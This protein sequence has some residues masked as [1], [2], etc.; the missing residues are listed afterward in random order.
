MKHKSNGR[1]RYLALLICGIIIFCSE[2]SSTH[3]AKGQSIDGQP[4]SASTYR[5]FQVIGTE[6]QVERMI[7]IVSSN[8]PQWA[9]DVNQ[10]KKR[11]TSAGERPFFLTPIPFVVPP[12]NSQEPFYNHNHQPAITWLPNGDLLAIWYTTQAEHGT[13]L[14]VLASRLRANATQWDPSSEFFKAENH[15]MHGSSL[16]HDG[17]GTIYHF[18]GK[19]PDGETSWAKLALLMRTSN[20]NGVTWTAPLAIA[21]EYRQRNQVISD[22]LLTRNGTLIVACDASPESNGGTALHISRNHGRTWFD[23]GLDKMHPT[24]AADKTGEG[25]IAGIHAKVVELDDGR[26]LAFG[27]GDTINGNMP[28]SISSD[29]GQHWNYT[30]SEFPPIG[31]G[32]R[33]VLRRLN[34]GPILFVSFTRLNQVKEQTPGLV[35]MDQQGKQIRGHGLFAAVSFDDGK[36]W[37]V[38]KLLTPGNGIWDGGAWTKQFQAS[39]NRAEPAGYLAVTQTP[40][41]TIHLI[42]SRLHYRFNLAWLLQGT[43]HAKRAPE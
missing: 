5:R 12:T 36:T 34:E 23:S 8:V 14:T 19:G 38:R 15:N 6:S 3:S 21:A 20:D 24:F 28:M 29:E 7:P 13:E 4:N 42:S 1:S 11:W 17:N 22:S 43:L 9:Q 18:N 40:D 27:R 41:Q 10:L 33:L 37:P 31:S 16:L 26:W 39:A 30:A 2:I 25:T 32:Q 35:L